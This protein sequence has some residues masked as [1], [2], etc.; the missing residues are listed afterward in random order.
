MAFQ[1]TSSQGGWPNWCMTQEKLWTFNSHPHKEDD[2]TFPVFFLAIFIFQLTS[3]QGG[4]LGASLN[5]NLGS[6]FN[7][8]PHKEDDLCNFRHDISGRIL[9]THILT[10]RMTN[11]YNHILAAYIFQL[12]SSQGGWHSLDIEI[13][14]PQTFNSHPHKEDDFGALLIVYSGTLFQLTSSQGGWR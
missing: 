11:G 3:S 10:R 1:L 9:S 5:D 4:W 12:T 14:L 6:A 13:L 7:S 8:H 2:A